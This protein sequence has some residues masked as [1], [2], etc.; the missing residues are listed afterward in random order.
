MRIG[1]VAQP[2]YIRMTRRR[3]VLPHPSSSIPEEDNG[4]GCPEG[5]H[6][7][8]GHDLLA[9]GLTAVV[10]YQLRRS[11][12]L[13]AVSFSA[14]LARLARASPRHRPLSAKRARRPGS[15]CDGGQHA[16][17]GSE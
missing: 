4:N 16:E 7:R 9:R 11:D 15:T 10:P 14:L 6:E 1:A 13:G 8:H 5:T 3:S 17:S 12:S 2:A